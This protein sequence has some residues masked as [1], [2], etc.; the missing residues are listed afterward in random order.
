MNKDNPITTISFLKDNYRFYIGTSV[1][2][3]ILHEID[4]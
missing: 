3:I 1:G 2:S 4:K